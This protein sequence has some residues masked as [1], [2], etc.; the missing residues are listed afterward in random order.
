MFNTKSLI[1]IFLLVLLPATSFAGEDLMSSMKSQVEKA[2]TTMSADSD[3]TTVTEAMPQADSKAGGGLMDMLTSQLGVTSEQAIGGAGAIFAAA[4]GN[5]PENDFS[6]LSKAIPD[7][8]SMLS[9]APDLGGSSGLLSTAT[10]MLG[11]GDDDKGGLTSMVGPAFQALGMDGGM[12]EQFLPI[13]LNY[14]N[15]EGGSQLMG[16]LQKALL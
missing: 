15:S 8:G 12:V 5:M 11:G 3:K 4:Q 16:M 6:Q 9:A 1:S 7:M 2:Q 13:I 10:S 14:V